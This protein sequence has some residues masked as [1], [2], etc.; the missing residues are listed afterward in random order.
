VTFTPSSYGARS[1]N[2]SIT[3]SAGTQT[4]GLSGVAPPTTAITAPANGATVSGTATVTATATDTAGIGSI[5]IYID[6]ALAASGTTSPLNYSWNSLNVANGTHTIYSKAADLS[7][8]A[9]TSTT[10]SVTVSNALTQLVKNG[11]FEAGN[12]NYWTAGGVDLPVVV[13]GHT[14]V[15]TYSAQLGAIAPPEP[16]G[17][18]SIYQTITIPSGATTATLNFYYWASCADTITN[19]WQEAQIQSSSGATL[20]QVMKVCSNTQTWTQVTYN[21]IAY[22]GQTI[23]LY[24]N[25]HENGN[26]NLTYMYLDDVGVKAD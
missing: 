20:A 10:I 25:V 13:T 8:N 15:G 7:G 2:L 1:A 22:K 23:R 14:H 18:S 9:A 3:D 19:D 4:A 5:Q 6:G 21:V 17:D 11:S 12:L 16:N 24:F 26:G